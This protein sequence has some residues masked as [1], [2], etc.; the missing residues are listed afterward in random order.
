M[1]QTYSRGNDFGTIKNFRQKIAMK[2]FGSNLF[3][4]KRFCNHKRFSTKSLDENLWFKPIP[5][6]M[7]LQP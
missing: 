3:P 6:E 5:E 2:I 4:R 7:S 1:V